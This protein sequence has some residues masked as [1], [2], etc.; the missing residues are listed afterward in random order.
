MVKVKKTFIKFFF[1]ERWRCL[2]CGCEVFDQKPFCESC[3]KSLP[4]NDKDICDHCGRKTPCPTEYCLSCKEK[5]VDLDKGRSAFDYEMPIIGLIHKAKFG[6][7]KYLMRVFADVLTPIYLKNYFNADYIVY[8]PMTKKAEKKRGYNQT[9]L[10]ADA[11][12]EKIGVPVLD[13][14]EKVKETK[15]Q[16]GLKREERLKNLK[17]S[18]KVVDKK[19]VKD[20][21][22]LIV[23][24]VTTTGATLS[25]IATILKKAGAKKVYALT[26]AS[27][28]MKEKK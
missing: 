16:R 14:L 23:D 22:V 17:D 20:K 4:Y 24:D 19:S 26:I 27:V 3:E 10:L 15:S 18:F 9:K 2:S 6:E 25:L 28:G 7:G 5:L 8:V 1:N 11:L 21:S 12:S 13:C